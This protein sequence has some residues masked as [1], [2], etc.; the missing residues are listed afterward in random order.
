VDITK[1]NDDSG[2]GKSRED[3][4]EKTKPDTAPDVESSDPESEAEFDKWG[5]KLYLHIPSRT[6]EQKYNSPYGKLYKRA[7]AIFVPTPRL[8]YNQKL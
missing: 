5:N 1:I 6:E 8:T 7:P 2:D 3:S 4:V